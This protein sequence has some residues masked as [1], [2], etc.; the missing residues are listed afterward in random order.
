MN[1][2]FA[3]AIVLLGILALALIISTNISTQNYENY[4]TP[5]FLETKNKI[6]NYTVILNQIAQ[7]CYLESSNPKNCIDSNSDLILENL[8]LLNAPFYCNKAVFNEILGG[9]FE[10]ELNCES[11]LILDEK[12]IFSNYFTKEIK[13]IKAS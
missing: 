6:S 13:I 7:N 2:G 4:H 1:K 10:G 9:E 12:V 11:K 8:G 3:T 5:A